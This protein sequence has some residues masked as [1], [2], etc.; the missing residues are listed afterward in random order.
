MIDE[1]PQQWPEHGRAG[2]LNRPGPPSA[3]D[4]NAPDTNAPGPNVA[5]PN[6]SHPSPEG[7]YLRLALELQ[8]DALLL[9][10]GA[11]ARL[12]ARTDP[13]TD[14]RTDSSPDVDQET[15][16]QWMVTDLGHLVQLAASCRR[17]NAALPAQL[18]PSATTLHGHLHEQ[19]VEQ[20]TA[21]YQELTK[22]LELALATSAVR[23]HAPVD[24]P[25]TP[26]GVEA[27]CDTIQ[28]R[29]RR[30]EMGRCG[31]RKQPDRE[32]HP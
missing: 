10:V 1:R 9:L 4:T 19:V 29:R 13:R 21:R 15:A 26:S 27:V 28:R 14:L 18:A 31:P 24:H 12:P 20:L 11:H 17:L 30:L 23:R 16:W 3:P 32:D 7:H 5:Q 25:L 6:G 2:S 22:L 8:L